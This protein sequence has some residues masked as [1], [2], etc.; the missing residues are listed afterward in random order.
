[1]TKIGEEIHL[2]HI[3]TG[4]GTKT[5]F[6]VELVL[7][8]ELM[9]MMQHDYVIFVDPVRRAAERGVR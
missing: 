8:L 9:H 1:M 2:C 7:W 5:S 4:L 3:L 6:A